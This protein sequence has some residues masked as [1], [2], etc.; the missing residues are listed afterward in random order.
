MFKAAFK[1]FNQDYKV[2]TAPKGFSKDDA[3]IDLI[4]LKS[5]FVV[6]H[7][8]DEEVFSAEY[9]DNLLY[10]FQLLRPYF[11]YMSDVLTTDLNGVSLLK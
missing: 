10:H 9:L 6:H 5:Y 1:G 8:S 3:N 2:K 7:F 11:D 4:R